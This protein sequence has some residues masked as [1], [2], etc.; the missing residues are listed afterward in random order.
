[1]RSTTVIP[2]QSSSNGGYSSR[3]FHGSSS[4]FPVLSGAAAG[5]LYGNGAREDS[6]Y[7]TSPCSDLDLSNLYLAAAGTPSGGY[8]YA[9]SDVTP[10]ASYSHLRKYVYQGLQTTPMNSL[11]VVDPCAEG[12][13][14]CAIG[15][16][17][18]PEEIVNLLGNA[19]QQAEMTSQTT[20]RKPYAACRGQNSSSVEYFTPGIGYRDKQQ[21]QQQLMPSSNSD[22]TASSGSSTNSSILNEDQEKSIIATN[23]CN[24]LNENVDRWPSK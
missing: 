19:S 18:V 23:L 1:M 21:Q 3:T 9:Q 22:K 16:S 20:T 24:Y 4:A 10:F 2:P 12:S 7:I 15:G 5:C 13:G 8:A 17:S 14:G 11:Q 6:G